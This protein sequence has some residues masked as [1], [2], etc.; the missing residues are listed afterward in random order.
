MDG[1]AGNRRRLDLH[2]LPSAK[3]PM[4]LQRR[5]DRSASPL[6]L[7]C[8]R[9]RK[10]LAEMTA[11]GMQPAPSGSAAALGMHASAAAA[12]LGLPY[13]PVAPEQPAPDS[14]ILGV[15]GQEEEPAAAAE[16]EGAKGAAGPSAQ[17]VQAAAEARERGNACFKKRQYEQ[18]STPD[19]ARRA[20][21]R[22]HV[23]AA[24]GTA[25]AGG[26]CVCAGLAPAPRVGMTAPRIPAHPH[27][28]AGPGPQAVAHYRRATGLDP[29]SKFGWSNLAAALLQLLRWDEAVDACDRVGGRAGAAGP[30]GGPS[31]PG[32][33]WHARARPPAC[34]AG[35]T[36]CLR[37]RRPRAAAHALPRRCLRCCLQSVLAPTC[38]HT[39]SRRPHAHTRSRRPRP[40]PSP[41]RPWSWTPALTR[42]AGGGRRAT[43]AAAAGSRRCSKSM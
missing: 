19:L 7:R 35:C 31:L 3:Q 18:A 27:P 11:R 22:R 16:E 9:T 33:A 30:E 43:G 24:C 42:R 26:R 28:L 1:P 23:G 13:V 6:S 17:D 29:S 39:R 14:S 15:G 36:R 32:L 4:T 8:R 10:V 21:G 38:A 20:E 40:R 5:A 25:G 41:G 2:L 37:G 12:Q 34:W